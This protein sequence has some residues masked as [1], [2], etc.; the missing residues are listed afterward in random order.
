VIAISQLLVGL[1]QRFKSARRLTLIGWNRQRA[2]AT[3]AIMAEVRDPN[4]LGSTLTISFAGKT[5]Q[6]TETTWLLTD[7][8]KVSHQGKSSEGRND[9]NKEQHEK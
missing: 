2:M 9:S 7:V 5:V 3:R 1:G 6:Y 4:P 8:F